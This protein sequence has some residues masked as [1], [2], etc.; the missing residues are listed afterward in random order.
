M[1]ACKKCGKQVCTCFMEEGTTTSLFGNG[2][3]SSPW[4]VRP[5][6]PQY[7]YA[8]HVFQHQG[9]QLVNPNTDVIVSFTRDALSPL[10]EG[11]MWDSSQPTRLTAP[12]DGLYLIGGQAST[13]HAVWEVWIA[14]N[15]NLGAPLVRRT[16]TM[17]NAAGSV[18]NFNS[19]MTIVRLNANDY[20][21]LV[22]RITLFSIAIGL[23]GVGTLSNVDAGPY[24]SAQWIGA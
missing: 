16:T 19:V 22:M 13:T 23:I 10:T 5:N 7:R 17:L 6:T 12:I 1:S 2:R 15:G 4:Q 24:L 18:L 14:K 3:S 9:G 21:E 20:I 8:G 11:N